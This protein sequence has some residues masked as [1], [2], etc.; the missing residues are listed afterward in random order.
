MPPPARWN[1]DP[2]CGH[3]VVCAWQ[4]HYCTYIRV[5]KL[6]TLQHPQSDRPLERLML[7]GLQAFELWFRMLLA[8]LERAH[9]EQQKPEPNEFLLNKLFARS[10]AILRLLN[11]Q[12]QVVES[13]LN[14][15]KELKI[16]VAATDQGS[17]SA[18]FSALL[19]AVGRLQRMLPEI[20]AS[21]HTHTRAAR[22]VLDR[23]DAWAPR[24]HAWVSRLVQSSDSAPPLSTYL[25]LETLLSIQNGV[26]AEWHPQGEDPSSL[27]DSHPLSNDEL[28]FIVVHQ[29]FELWFG[30]ILQELDRFRIQLQTSGEDLSPAIIN[31]R[32]VVQIQRLLCEQIFIPATMTPMDFLSFRDQTREQNG[33]TY[34]RGLSPASGTESYQF[35]EIE[36]LGGLK[37]SVAYREFLQGNPQLHMRFLTPTQQRRIAETSLPEL[38]DKLIEQHG[39]EQ[40]VEIF[41]PSE[42]ENPHAQLAEL[43]DLLLEFDQFFQLWRVNHLTMVQ[44]MIGRKSGTGYLGPEYLRETAGMGM[45][46]EDDRIFR[47][48]QMRPRFFERLWEARTRMQHDGPA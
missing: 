21:P 48:P 8:D 27:S 9:L 14:S 28:L 47:T 36:I 45:Q 41:Q 35:R 44:S 1:D 43:A 10:T 29:A 26:K 13:L 5:P 11:H 7:F 4:T 42:H 34:V 33:V 38:F 25:D 19:R 22:E 31:L 17:P 30:A 40:A 3:I 16:D 23:M 46:G 6:L 39:I 24:Y 18:Q 2:E 37:G 32:R 15:G 12:N 20:P